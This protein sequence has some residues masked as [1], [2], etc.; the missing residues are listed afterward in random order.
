MTSGCTISELTGELTTRAL[1]F[2]LTGPSGDE[3]ARA[4][5]QDFTPAFGTVRACICASDLKSGW[6]CLG[7]F[8]STPART[9]TTISDSQILDTESKSASLSFP[10]KVK[11]RSVGVLNLEFNP[12]LTP[13]KKNELEKLLQ[14]LAK[15]IA[16][17]FFGRAP[18]ELYTPEESE[19]VGDGPEDEESALHARIHRHHFTERQ[20]KVLHQMAHGRSHAKIA[21]ELGFSVST[22]RHEMIRI[23]HVLSVES[24]EE[25]VVRANALGLIPVNFPDPAALFYN[26]A[27]ASSNTFNASDNN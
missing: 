15:P 21:K 9:H 26:V 5:A 25:A 2:L 22:I 1:D 23:F 13:A 7:D 27:N 12:Q 18:L 19:A 10:L 24:R 17:Y 20:L 16:I 11:N 4:I 3:V 14:F 8:G 6:F